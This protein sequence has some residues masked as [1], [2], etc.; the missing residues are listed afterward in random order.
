MAQ[1]LALTE[2]LMR[3][4]HCLFGRRF[5]ET[6]RQALGVDRDQREAARRKADEHIRDTIDQVVEDV[7]DPEVTVIDYVDDQDAELTDEIQ[8][9]RDSLKAQ[10]GILDAESRTREH[11]TE[12]LAAAPRQPGQAT[13][14]EQS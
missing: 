1:V 3:R 7:L 4:L 12:L 11:I 2:C 10:Q 8:A 13:E 14:R 9:F 5:A 6:V